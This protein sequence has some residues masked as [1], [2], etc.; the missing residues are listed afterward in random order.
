[1]S[2]VHEQD[3][4]QFLRERGPISNELLKRL[5]GSMD[6]DIASVW[7]RCMIPAYLMGLGAAALKRIEY[8]EA[9][10]EA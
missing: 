2:T 8:L 1:M 5:L 4:E 9:R 6:G 7:N 10:L 3:D